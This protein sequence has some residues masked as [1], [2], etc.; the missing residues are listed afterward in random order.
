MSTRT[1]TLILCLT[2]MAL[3]AGCDNGMSPTP[4]AKGAPAMAAVPKELQPP[5]LPILSPTALTGDA[6]DG[7]VYLRWNLQIEDDRVIGWNVL[8][9]APAKRTLND[10]PLTDP[11]LVVRELTNGT[12]YTFTVVGVLRDGSVT[13]QSNTVTVTP[14]DVGV[15]KLVPIALPERHGQE[16]VGGE[17]LSFGEFKDIIVGAD[18]AGRWNYFE[19]SKV[20]FPDGQELLYD[21]YRPI[22][23][24]TADGMHLINPVHFGNGLDIGKFDARGLPMVIPPEG[25]RGPR[26]AASADADPGH[27]PLEQAAAAYRHVQ[28]GTL[29]P[30]ITDPLTMSQAGKDRRNDA[31]PKWFEPTIDGDRVTFHYWLP[32][33]AMGYKSFTYVLVWETWWPIQRERHGTTY[34]GLARLI[35]VEMLSAFKDG[36]QVMINNGFGPNGSRQGVKS[37]STGF[38]EPGHEIVD[39]SGDRNKSVIFQYPKQPRQ[40]SGYHPAHDALQGSPL[41]FYDWGTGSLTITARSLYYHASNNSSSY[42]EHGADGVWPNLAWDMALSGERTAVDT[43]EYLYT[44]DVRQPLPQ[45]YVNARFEAYG[46]V[47]RRMGVQDVIGS[48][49][50]DAPHWQI[51]NHGGPVEFGKKYPPQLKGQGLDTLAVYHDLWHA[52][53]ITVE[54]EYRFDENHD[55]NPDL[56]AM[57]KLIKDAGYMPGFWFR[58]EFTK[59]SVPAAMSKKIPTAEVY[60]GYS[61]CHYPDLVP[62]L[63]ERGIPLFRENPDWVRVRKDGSMPVNTPYQWVPMSLATDWFDRIIWPS[64]W[65]SAKLGFE[66]TLVDGGF[67]GMQGV[68]YAPKFQGKT[69]MAVPAQPYWWRMWRSLEHVGIKTFGECTMGWKGANVVAGGL[70][71]EHYAWMFQMGW[72][73]G[74]QGAFS[75][76]EGTHKLFQLYN[77]VGFVRDNPKVAAVR[78]YAIEFHRKNPAPDWIEFKDLKQLEEIE[79]EVPVGDSPVAAAG[80][81][82]TEEKTHKIK[83]APWIWTDVIWHYNDGTSV[84]YPSFES[85]D[86]DA[87][88]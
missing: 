15:A 70:A 5:P 56:K 28:W 54:D 47:S 10:K 2:A 23:W 36:Y 8:Q 55:C 53:P 11:A 52:V 26:P 78:R 49:C 72:Y 58:P 84:V 37:Y 74:C 13:P 21:R 50:M 40:G 31:Y 12:A 77:G 83:V 46:D 76:P 67:G 38:R 32:L 82:T 39:F 87:V 17:R 69:D 18:G 9:T 41:I 19:T 14:R 33:D 62:L 20:V 34:N 29:H 45:R 44:G 1:G 48:V 51:R 27:A 75:S 7:R 66:R 35:E 88:E 57:C 73:I 43:V 42:I 3:L 71:D 30:F 86:W 25:L 16:L 79:Y 80:T 60:Y 59:T 24:K 4:L 6:G 64:M 85:I 22:D 68:D 65:M 63:K 81:R 61:G